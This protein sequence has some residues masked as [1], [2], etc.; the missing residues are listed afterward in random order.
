MLL[1]ALTCSLFCLAS[2]CKSDV[3]EIVITSKTKSEPPYRFEFYSDGQAIFVRHEKKIVEPESA[4]AYGHNLQ[5]YLSHGYGV[6]LSDTFNIGKSKFD[7]IVRIISG[8]RQN[9]RQFTYP[10]ISFGVFF[11]TKNT[12]K[13]DL[14]YVGKLGDSP[15]FSDL[16]CTIFNDTNQTSPEGMLPYFKEEFGVNCR[17]NGK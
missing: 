5:Y 14:R 2:S 15:I 6:T 17:S 11:E 12:P 16:L 3:N 4:F 13:N 10:T 9:T 7:S 1:L 8:I